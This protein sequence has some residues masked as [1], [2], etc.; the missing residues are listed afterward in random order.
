M[1][2]TVMIMTALKPKYKTHHVDLLFF[3]VK[4][5]LIPT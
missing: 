2:A 5:P 1:L 3:H 4:E